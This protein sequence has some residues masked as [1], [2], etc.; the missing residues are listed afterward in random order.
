MSAQ[1]EIAQKKIAE[2]IERFEEQLES[3]KKSDYNET[4]TRRDFIDPF[5]KALGW[6]IDNEQ[7]YAQSYREVIHEDKIK[8]G[9]A[10]KSPD[11][12]FRISDAKRLFFVE[13]KKPSVAIKD[14]IQPAF[15]V[16]RYGWS[17]KLSVSII[18]DFEE[19]SVYDCTK[20]PFP[21]DKASKARIKYL[22]FRDYLKEFDFLWGT[23]SKEQVL[24]GGLDKYA[25]SNI[26]KRGT[27]TVDKDFLQSL[28]SWRTYLATSIALN[29]KNLDEDEINFVVQQTIDR[30][31]FLHI[32]EDRSVEPYGNLQQCLTP[33]LSKGE[34]VC[35]HELFKLFQKADEKYNSGIFD[36]KKDRISKGLKIDNKVIKTIITDLYFPSPYAFDVMPVEIL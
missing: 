11:Y 12:S 31:I 33:T 25:Q 9:R 10:T 13:A 17:A 2:L 35:Y 32:A 36:F 5:F 29:N 3:Y 7:G 23:F 24:K 22:T 34:G 26:Q 4:L 20:K 28:D 19:F 30:I 6:D 16:R 21:T 27:E 14:E 18:T 1:K 15:Q 8:V